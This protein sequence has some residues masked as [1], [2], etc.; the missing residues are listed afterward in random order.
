MGL[1]MQGVST[2]PSSGTNWEHAAL[3][4]L[5]AVLKVARLPHVELTQA[6][7][8]ALPE[9]SCSLPTGTTIGKR[10]K[11][12]VH[13]RPGPPNAFP[14]WLLGEYTA[15]PDPGLVGITWRRIVVRG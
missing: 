6:E 5:S 11:L 13:F 8:E 10:W 2:T 7:L 3:N 12:D 15:H 1:R 14:A 4:Q 9:Y